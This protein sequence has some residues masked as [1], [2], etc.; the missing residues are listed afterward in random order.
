VTMTERGPILANLQLEGVFDH[1]LFNQELADFTEKVWTS[2]MI[3]IEP[4]YVQEEV[5]RQDSI[6]FRITN[7]F[8]VPV[9]VRMEHGFSWDFKA[10]IARPE[11][12]LQP[13]S[14]EFVSMELTARKQKALDLMSPVKL[15]A[16]VAVQEEGKGDYFLPFEFNVSPLRKY[17]LKKSTGRVKADG[18]LNEWA[19]LPYT[20][21]TPEGGRFGVSYDD[22]FVYVGIQV[23]DGEVINNAEG[24]TMSQDFVGFVLDGQPMAKSV[25]EKGEGSFKNSLYFLVSPEDKTGKSSVRDLNDAEKQLEWKCVRNKEGYAFELAVPIS[26]LQKQQG[27]HWQNMRLNVIVQDKDAKSSTRVTWKNSWN[28]RDNIPGSGMF[29]R[30]VNGKM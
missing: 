13:N 12:M 14:V 18:K 15:K 24:A 5:F 10:D 25:S 26:Y 4:L 17:E 6:R 8:D 27:N 3:Q 22:S 16:E 1:D 21:S 2:D 11:L 30:N 20:L 23:N 29:F 28:S 9:K 19:T 7:P